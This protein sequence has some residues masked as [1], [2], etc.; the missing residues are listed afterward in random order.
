MWSFFWVL[1]IGGYWIIR[2]WNESG[3]KFAYQMR[4]AENSVKYDGLYFCDVIFEAAIENL[5]ISHPYYF[6]KEYN[7][8]IVEE[9]ELIKEDLRDIFG[10]Y[11]EYFSGCMWYIFPKLVT[12]LILSK[13]QKLSEN[14]SFEVPRYSMFY[15]N[16]LSCCE[17]ND[18]SSYKDIVGLRYCKK[19][20]ENI[21]IKYPDFTLV[22]D[23]SDDGFH[24]NYVTMRHRLSLNGTHKAR[25]LWDDTPLSPDTAP[26]P[27]ASP[28]TYWKVGQR[29]EHYARYLENQM[30][31]R[32]ESIIYTDKSES[33]MNRKI[34]TILS[35]EE[36]KALIE[37]EISRLI[38]CNNTLYQI[39]SNQ[40]YLFAKLYLMSLVRYIPS[41]IENN[42]SFTVCYSYDNK[43]EWIE[44]IALMRIVNKKL[45]STGRH[46]VYAESEI[47][48]PVELN[49]IS[50][51]HTN[52]GVFYL[53]NKNE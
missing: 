41:E 26:R 13:S 50:K 9:F 20:E 17:V 38:R 19:I 33:E 25:R 52:G 29:N 18:M 21:R 31:S 37:K 53:V 40:R 3:T 4:D 6:S 51:Q 15:C 46:F 36:K 2:L 42:Q 30:I 27:I 47:S 16:Q 11:P 34:D 48:D 32:K 43:H 7:G 24:P 44:D 39:S 14:V 49:D 12:N 23:S 35:S 1:L 45:K 10:D 5:L 8:E 28:P 22:Y